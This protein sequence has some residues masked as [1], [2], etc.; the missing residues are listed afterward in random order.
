M[1]EEICFAAFVLG[2]ISVLAGIALA[3][4]QSE[5]YHITTSVMAG[6]DELMSSDNCERGVGKSTGVSYYNPRF[7][8][9]GVSADSTRGYLYYS[10]QAFALKLQKTIRR[11]K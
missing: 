11:K 7:I 1:K 6:G 10:F 3:R 9:S 8:F 4:M 5:N 2:F